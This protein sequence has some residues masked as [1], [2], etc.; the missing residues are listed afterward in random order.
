MTFVESQ[1]W[2]EYLNNPERRLDKV[3]ASPVYKQLSDKDVTDLFSLCDGNA[4][5]EEETA[6]LQLLS[7]LFHLSGLSSEGEAALET[8]VSRA[9]DVLVA[10]LKRR[11]FDD[12]A[13][14]AALLLNAAD[15]DLFGQ[16]LINE[17]D[18]AVLAA[19]N[20]RDLKR[21]VDDLADLVR[22]VF[23]KKEPSALAGAALERLYALVREG[24]L[25]AKLAAEQL[26]GKKLAARR[27]PALE[28]SQRNAALEDVRT[29]WN[30]MEEAGRT[31]LTLEALQEQANL[32]GRHRSREALDFI[33][34]RCI[35]RLRAGVPMKAILAVL[36]TPSVA[37]H[38][39]FWYYA[40]S[41]GESTTQVVLH[42]NASGEFLR[43]GV[44][45]A[46]QPLKQALL[47]SEFWKRYVGGDRKFIGRLK[48][49][50]APADISPLIDFLATAPDAQKLDAMSMLY[51]AVLKKIE[52]TKDEEQ[53]LVAILEPMMAVYPHP[54][55]V[56][57]FCLMYRLAPLGAERFLRESVDASRIPEDLFAT[58]L[59]DLLKFSRASP[60]EVLLPFAQ[61]DGARGE[62]ARSMLKARGVIEAGDLH[63]LAQAWKESRRAKDLADLHA[64]HLHHRH[65]RPIAPL[66]ELLGAPTQSGPAFYWYED[67]NHSGLLLQEDDRGNLELSELCLELPRQFRTTAER[68]NG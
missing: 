9:A 53:K 42:Q 17:A 34:Q 6:A 36:G 49:N 43:N 15:P 27:A 28:R 38:N 62:K 61:W 66:L 11:F 29:L 1:E 10:L 48:D 39:T 21:I 8:A 4:A 23:P 16:F 37:C 45:A 47:D 22:P 67:A 55:G 20:E 46:G 18:L 56:D 25:P 58:Y 50:I 35:L 59:H 65:G 24:G 26:W 52:I 60:A 5:K 7:D 19:L 14:S 44:T 41:L 32:W 30:C 40:E 12:A 2:Q 3:L 57:A 33:H 13:R 64:F 31:E 63:A 54:P 51:W 68:L